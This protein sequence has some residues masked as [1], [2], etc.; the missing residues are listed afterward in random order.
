[1]RGSLRVMPKPRPV[2]PYCRAVDESAWVNSSNSLACC[3]AVM[4][5]PVSVTANSTQ[6]RP[7]I[8][9]CTR[10]F[11]S[12]CVVNLQALLNR[13]SRIWRSRMGSTVSIPSFSCASTT[14]LFLFCCASWR[15]VPTTSSMSG[16]KL[17]D[18][19]L[20]SSLPASIFERSS[21]WL[22]RPSRCWPARCTR[23]SGS[24]GFF[25]PEP[26]RVGDHHLGQADNGVERGAQLVAHAGHELR[27]VLARQFE[28]TALLLDFL[29][30]AGILDRQHR[31]GG[32]RP[33]EVDGVLGKFA[34]CLAPH[35]ERAHD[36]VEAPKWYEQ[37]RAIASLQH[38]CGRGD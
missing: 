2:P 6:L 23:L 25:L 34:G 32:E 24:A 20:S 3:S 31:L 9:L 37:P 35:H 10:S 36:L 18:S 33:Q 30:Q 21:T 5:M 26:R 17:T 11:T 29:E 12:P 7:S 14:R 38:D 22:M 27:L 16:S 19:G 13:L 1:M 4:P 8:T 28:L 15:A